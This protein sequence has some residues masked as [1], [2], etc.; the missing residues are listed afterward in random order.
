MEP[1]VAGVPT[2]FGPNYQDFDEA[3]QII[4]NESGF[5]IKK[6]KDFIDKMDLLLS[7]EE[8]ITLASNQAFN[9]IK[10]NIGAS[11]KLVK[12]ITS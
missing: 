8:K 10:K 5:V 1:A 2:F 12:E 3:V 7:K 4:N 11:N 6:G 9:L